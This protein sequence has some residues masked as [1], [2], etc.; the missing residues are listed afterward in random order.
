[1]PDLADTGGIGLPN[2]RQQHA[3]RHLPQELEEVM[4]DRHGVLTVLFG[5]GDELPYAEVHITHQLIDALLF[6]VRGD[7]QQPFPVEGV[8]D[9]LI[10]EKAPFVHRD[11]AA[12][13]K[14]FDPVGVG[15]QFER[16]IG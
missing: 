10:A 6:E 4:G 12:L 9:F 3:L 15:Q 8:L 14:K 1:M 16:G 5:R 7:G 11:F 2:G 13:F